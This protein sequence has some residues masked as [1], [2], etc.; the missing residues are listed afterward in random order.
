MERPGLFGKLKAG[1]QRS[2]EKVKAS[3]GSLFA[4]PRRLDQ[5]FFDELEEQLIAADVGATA[6]SRLVAALR[7]KKYASAD[8]VLVELKREMAALLLP[9]RPP[10]GPPPRLVMFVGVNGSG[11]TTTVAKV[12]RL[13]KE[14]GSSVLLVAAD[15]FRAAAGEQIEIWADRLGLPIVR[16]A[17]GADPAALVYD[18]IKAAEARGADYILI[19]TAGRMQTKKHLM[20][21][22]GK[23]RRIASRELPG[24]PHAT[25]LVLD[26]TVG[27]N[28]LV[29]CREFGQAVPLSGIVLTKADGTA[30]GGIVF[31][32]AEELHLPVEYIGVGE[33]A[34]D[35]LPFSPEGF[36]EAL[37][38]SR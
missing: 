24:A 18:G 38:E 29:Q 11:K 37:F 17:A 34:E 27:Q 26:A 5:A 8:E 9:A 22:L 25:L 14:Q 4:G 28:G 6:S 36:V 16:Q 32:V 21:E 10:Q 7:Q 3:V 33:K 2:R 30:R 23:M 31:S 13:L 19:D 35:L 15:T 20:A 1:L 12:G